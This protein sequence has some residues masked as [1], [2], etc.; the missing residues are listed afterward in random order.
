MTRADHDPE[1]KEWA[2]TYF[3]KTTF[4]PAGTLFARTLFFW[5]N[6]FQGVDIYCRTKDMDEELYRSVC[7]KLEANRE[8]LGDKIVDA[9]FKP[10]HS[11]M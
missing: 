3:S 10:K 9:M 6:F 5:I 2:I 7:A 11:K 1:G 4:T 8:I